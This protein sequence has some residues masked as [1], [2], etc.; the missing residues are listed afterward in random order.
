MAKILAFDIEATNLSANF[1]TILCIGYKEVGKKRTHILRLRD[2][3]CFKKDATD[4]SQLVKEFASIA[5]EADAWITYYG[6]RFDVPY[7]NTK[8]LEYGMHPMD[9]IHHMD[10][11]RTAKYRLKLNSN[12]LDT[13]QKAF[14]LPTSKTPL[15]PPVW[16]KAATGHGPSM[17]YVEQHCYYDVECLEEVYYKVRPLIAN[18]PNLALLDNMGQ[19]CCTKCGGKRYHKKGLHPKGTSK[20]TLRQRYKCLECGTNFYDRNPTLIVDSEGNRITTQVV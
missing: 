7:I 16:K 10:L 20:V 1:G 13:V 12:R 9:E 19:V 18:H 5:N 4:D 2:Y 11:W 17:K 14:H 6:A 3:P 8:L 15:D